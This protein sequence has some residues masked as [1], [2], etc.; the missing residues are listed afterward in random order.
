MKFEIV[1]TNVNYDKSICERLR[2][3]RKPI[4]I[5]GNANHAKLVYEYLRSNDLDIEAFVVDNQY[6]NA[7]E[8]IL[9]KDVCDLEKYRD[10][11]MK[12]NVVIGFCN[13]T[14]TRELLQS[15]MFGEDNIFLIWEPLEVYRWDEEYLKADSAELNIIYNDLADDYS[16]KVLQELVDA[17]LQRNGLKLLDLADDEQY[18][19]KLTYKEHS[20]NEVFIDCGAFDGDTIKK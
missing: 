13:V 10:K 1:N 20:E 12:Y 6:Y 9:D 19:N 2:Q 7:N 16:K 8:R 18:F 4:L 5:Y 11:I 14:R 17:K 3:E 15:S